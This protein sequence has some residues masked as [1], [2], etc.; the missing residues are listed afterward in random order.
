FK[1]DLKTGKFIEHFL[2]PPAQ[3]G[4]PFFLSAITLGKEGEAYV[5]DGINRA[6]YQ[7]RDDR[8]RRILHLPMLTS[9]SAIT[10]SGDGKR[11]Y[12]A[13]PQLGIIGL[14]LATLKPF[15]VRVPQKLSLEGIS[16]LNWH[17]GALIAV[18]A[19][20][21]PRRVMRF[22]LSPEGNTIVKVLPLEASNPQFGRP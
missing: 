1:F 19:G 8:F 5:A 21:N 16:A 13:D 2:S 10:V 7:V 11:L 22:D 17:D 6:I 4:Q 20:M 12:M 3:D 14:D 15:D 18:Q 9:I